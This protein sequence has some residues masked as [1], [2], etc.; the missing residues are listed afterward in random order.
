MR[1]RGAWGWCF[2]GLALPFLFV[3]QASSADAPC[4]L[5]A[6]KEL[7]ETLKSVAEQYPA[8]QESVARA[9]KHTAEYTAH[10]LT[11]LAK[12]AERAKVEECWTA[13]ERECASENLAATKHIKIQIKSAQYGV[14]GLGTCSVREQVQAACD[15]GGNNTP[16][17]T[18]AFKTRSC[19]V[20]E[21]A[22]L[23]PDRRDPSGQIDARAPSYRPNM[24]WVTYCC[25]GDCLNK[26]ATWKVA[27]VRSGDTLKLKCDPSALMPDR[28]DAA[29]HER[30]CGPHR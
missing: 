21:E 16:D 20:T 13:R 11:N 12:T 19:G 27:G 17:Q 6:S 30:V 14:S 25:V 24:L 8:T 28:C 9:V 10:C 22:Y 18:I 23:C 29:G 15:E 7:L 4:N 1:V 2:S 3:V 5:A 26:R